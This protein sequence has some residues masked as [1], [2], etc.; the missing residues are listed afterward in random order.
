MS[1]HDT[2]NRPR[3]AVSARLRAVTPY[4]PGQR[5]ISA[6]IGPTLASG[7]G[8]MGPRDHVQP[9]LRYTISQ[10]SPA[11]RWIA[12]GSSESWRGPRRGPK[13]F[14]SI[15][16]RILRVRENSSPRRLRRDHKIRD[17]S[18]AC[19]PGHVA[20]LVTTAVQGPRSA[21]SGGWEISSGR[22][23]H[24][25]HPLNSTTSEYHSLHHTTSSNDGS[26]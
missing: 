21:R 10:A 22:A 15:F 25:G 18:H 17:R 5:N 24:K 7:K 3:R 20:D 4:R 8:E 1:Y 16:G 19:E 12:W 14:P 11:L 26:G 2:G 9:S 23:N 13:R 6:N